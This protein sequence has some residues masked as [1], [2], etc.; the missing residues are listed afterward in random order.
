MPRRTN[1]AIVW[2]HENPGGARDEGGYWH[3]LEGRFEISPTFRSTVYPDGYRLTD[4]DRRYGRE[5]KRWS[6][7]T[8]REAKAQAQ[9]IIDREHGVGFYARPTATEE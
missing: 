5:V 9:D 7:D 2:V 3:S 6:F 8:I 4:N 1:Y